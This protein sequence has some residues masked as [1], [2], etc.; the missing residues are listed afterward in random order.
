MARHRAALLAVAGALAGCGSTTPAPPPAA[1]TATNPATPRVQAPG[2]TTSTLPLTT[3]A[4]AHAPLPVQRAPAGTPERVLYDFAYA[5]GNFNA[6]TAVAAR[7]VLA[8]LATPAYAAQLRAAAPQAELEAAR[9]LPP[10]ARNVSKI[11]SLQ[12]APAVGN[13]S[14]GE[15]IVSNTIQPGGRA[16]TPV[17]ESFTAT[18]TRVA[19]SWRV[20]DYTANVP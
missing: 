20:A 5:Y 16:N 19:G 2:P 6:R 9:G 12:V 7:D 8:S 3:T 4:P 18:L 15:V 14:T 13:T 1:T 17:S 11:I 10:G